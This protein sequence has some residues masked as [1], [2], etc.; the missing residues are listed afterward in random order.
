MRVL[1]YSLIIF[2]SAIVVLQVNA[3]Y[4]NVI[5][6]Q[7]SKSCLISKC[8]SYSDII[9]Y[10]NAS[11]VEKWIGKLGE[12]GREIHKKPNFNWAVT[13]NK[14]YIVLDPPIQ[15]K[16][17]LIEIVPRLVN[18]T[19]GLKSVKVNSMQMNIYYNNYRYVK[20]CRFATIE[21]KNI[22]FLL[23]D[24]INYLA[25]NCKYTKLN[26][27]TKT[28]KNIQPFDYSQFKEYK[29]KNWQKIILKQCIQTRNACTN[30]I[31]P[32]TSQR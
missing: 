21:A 24:T 5:G 12:N 25:S 20:D 32:F 10:D 27:L 22:D 13:T 28:T 6:I 4:E 3:E 19:G 1:A 7:I 17:K 2:F 8:L 14:T 26:T 16:I 23:P 30:D 18:Y 15:T 29:L 9:K 11:S 31:T